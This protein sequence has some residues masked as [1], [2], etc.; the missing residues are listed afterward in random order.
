MLLLWVTKG[1]CKVHCS[2]SISVVLDIGQLQ[3]QSLANNTDQRGTAATTIGQHEKSILCQH[4]VVCS[5]FEISP[6]QASYT[7]SEGLKI[8]ENPK[9]Y[10]C[11]DQKVTENLTN[12]ETCRKWD[13]L[14]GH[15]SRTGI[16][17]VLI[18]GFLMGT[19]NLID[20]E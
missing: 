18:L 11:T 20:S 9:F 4:T 12:E 16:E 5:P 3:H 15:L 19:Q 6:H 7:L 14:F 13:L 10:R 8:K 2:W 1:Q 17:S